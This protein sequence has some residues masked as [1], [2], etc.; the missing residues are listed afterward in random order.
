MKR[1]LLLFLCC[2]ASTTTLKLNAVAVQQPAQ[3]RPPVRPIAN[4]QLPQEIFTSI[5][6][7][8]TAVNEAPQRFEES[9]KRTSHFI[10]KKTA[11]AVLAT[12]FVAAALVFLYH[13]HAKA[14]QM[15]TPVPTLRFFDRF[16]NRLLSKST[17]FFCLGAL[18]YRQL[19]I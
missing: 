17:G 19:C 15:T 9:A 13:D 14:A 7:A 4:V 5:N 2:Y 11:F 18:A 8:I 6:N 16:K 1:F 10:I 12:L 3:N